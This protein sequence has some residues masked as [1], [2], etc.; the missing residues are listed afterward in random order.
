[1]AVSTLTRQS[2]GRRDNEPTAE[3]AGR[4]RISRSPDYYNL[5]LNGTVHPT[6]PI[7]YV[8][9]V[10]YTQIGVYTYDKDGALT[11]AG[12]APNTGVAPCWDAISSDGQYMYVADAF[13]NTISTYSLANPYAPS[14]I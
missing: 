4:C 14:E 6:L 1:M 3:R 10:S 13:S 8:N 2:K 7:V 5:P 11:F 12:A 9:F